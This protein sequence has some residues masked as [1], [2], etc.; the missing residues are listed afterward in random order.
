[1]LSDINVT[2]YAVDQVTQ[3]VTMATSTRTTYCHN[4]YSMTP[5]VC[6]ATGAAYYA[7]HFT[8]H[9]SPGT[10]AY[11]G[12]AFDRAT[13]QY[14]I[15]QYLANPSGSP[16]MADC[17]VWNLVVPA[18]FDEAIPQLQLYASMWRDQ[19]DRPIGFYDLMPV[20][21]YI[22]AIN[23]G[24]GTNI[25]RILKRG[26]LSYY[27]QV[28]SQISRALLG[29]VDH[30]VPRCYQ[31]D[32]DAVANWK[33]SA[34]WNLLEAIRLAAGKSVY[35]LV[36]HH[37][38]SGYGIL[39]EANYRASL[40]FVAAFPGITGVFLWEEGEEPAWYN[41]VITELVSNTGGFKDS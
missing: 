26:W 24:T 9:W 33:Y 10:P 21:Q 18:Q 30:L 34:S 1:M 12:A 35:P 22:H 31:Q 28:G 36:W 40:Q 7:P 13:I 14:W 27:M 16:V 8:Y 41:T 20:F 5:T 29:H 39:S 37:Y 19:T 6:T 4:V 38:T 2:E 17:E 25:T 11:P 15:D 32:A 3:M 23:A